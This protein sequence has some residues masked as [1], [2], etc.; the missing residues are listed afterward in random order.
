MNWT[1]RWEFDFDP[2]LPANLLAQ[3]HAQAGRVAQARDINLVGVFEVKWRLAQGAIRMLGNVWLE[4]VLQVEHG[5][6]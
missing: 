1:E 2:S 5:D 6:L 3:F 4:D